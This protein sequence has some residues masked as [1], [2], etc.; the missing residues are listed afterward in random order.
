MAERVETLTEACAPV[1]LYLTTFRRNSATT[2]MSIEELAKV[3][4]REIEAVQEHC[5]KDRR[6]RPLFDRVFYAI[7]AT[8]DQ[9]VLSSAWPQ[10]AGWSMNLL[11]LH[12]FQ[13]AEG[14]KKFYRLVEEVLNDPTDAAAELAELLFTCTALGFQGELLGE[15][16]ELERRRRQVYEKA[17]LPG[18]M[19]ELLAPDAYGRNTARDRT[20]LPT[21][22]TLRFLLIAVCAL[23]FMFLTSTLLAKISV[24]DYQQK[25]DAA[26]A[27]LASDAKP[28]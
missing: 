14:G 17:R 10:R 7:V 16:K 8:A 6:L 20:R 4:R 18:A 21:V 12:Y 9:V 19:G 23:L 25:I 15:K 5:E 24:H 22:G 27:K 28:K 3:L 1:F 11:E 2:T 26:R 13:S